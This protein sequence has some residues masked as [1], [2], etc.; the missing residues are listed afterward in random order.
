MLAELLYEPQRYFKY[1]CTPISLASLAALMRSLEALS[2]LHSSQKQIEI[3]TDAKISY[4]A[5]LKKSNGC[6]TA[7]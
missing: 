6:K 5:S 7:E 3:F 2:E 1:I 4:K